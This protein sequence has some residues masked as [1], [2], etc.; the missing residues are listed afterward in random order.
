MVG[1]KWFAVIAMLAAA[2]TAE[3]PATIA[4]PNEVVLDLDAG[5]KA[6][7]MK[8]TAMRVPPT[9]EYLEDANE[10]RIRHSADTGIL[11]SHMKWKLKNGQSH[12]KFDSVATVRKAAAQYLPQAVESEVDIEK[13]ANGPV[14]VTLATLTARPGQRFNIAGGYPDGCVTTGN[15]VSGASVYAI[16]IASQTCSSNTHKQALAAVLGAHR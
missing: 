15:I 9:R 5:W 8:N 14:A 16:S 2:A 3:P 1:R 10:I 11:V 12:D 4:L 6:T 7:S 13:R